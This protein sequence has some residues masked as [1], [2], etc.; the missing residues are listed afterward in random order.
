ME[1]SVATKRQKVINHIHDDIALLIVSKLPVKTLK[2]FGCVCK[3]WTLLFEDTHF[4]SIYRN[5]FIARNHVDHEGTSY[6]L[7]HT[8]NDYKILETSMYFLSSERSKNMIKLDYLPSFQKDNQ[9]IEILSSRSINGILCISIFRFDEERLALWNP[10]T[11]EFKIIPPSNFECVPYRDFEPLN[12]GFG[13]DHV[14]NDYKVI[15]RATFDY[16]T[17]YDCIRLDISYEPEWEIYSFRN[18]S[19]TKFD[20]DFP[21]MEIPYNSYEIIQ[22]YMDGMCHWWYK[23]DCHLFETSLVSFDV[24]NELFI[25]TP[26]P[27]YND[28][29]LDL[30]WVKRHLVTLINESIALISYC[31]EM[32]TFHISILDEIDVKESW[33]KLFNVGPL[34]CVA[35][36]IGGGKNGNIFLI[37]NNEELACFDLGTMMIEEL[38]VEG[39]LCQTVIYKQ[40]LLPI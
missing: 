3:S 38:G 4:M 25:T 36:P 20:F 14:R 6:L 26:M 17:Y 21:L 32:T 10:A 33:T 39:K 13:Y 19:W 18:N 7:Q 9:Y 1:K 23:S 15:R 12:H 34:S 2:R 22:F 37:R 40:N 8:I 28:D 31:G 35:R 11:E 5:N 24:S 16:L 29:I 27:R 30:N